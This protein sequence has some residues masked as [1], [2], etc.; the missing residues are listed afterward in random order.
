M[1]VDVAI[2]GA[3]ESRKKLF[4]RKRAKMGTSDA[5]QEK[6]APHD[7]LLGEPH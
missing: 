1:H 3:D 2:I 4:E 6:G 5:I 7:H